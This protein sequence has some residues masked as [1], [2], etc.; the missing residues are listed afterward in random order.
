VNQ[1]HN[2][3]HNQVLYSAW[4]LPAQTSMLCLSLTSDCRLFPGPQQCPGSVL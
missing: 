3:K 2:R 1:G 4:L